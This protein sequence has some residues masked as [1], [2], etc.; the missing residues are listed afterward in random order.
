MPEPVL[1]IEPHN[2]D[3]ALFAAYSM[4]AAA[5]ADL[6]T[7]LRSYRQESLPVPI[8]YQERELESA[9]AADVLGVNEWIQW[10]HRDDGDLAT[11]A[12]DLQAALIDMIDRPWARVFAPLVE[13][14]GHEHH[15][16]IGDLVALIA[17]AAGVP[18]TRYATYRR[19]SGRTRTAVAVAVERDWPAR[20]YAA[21][22]C[23]PSQI[24]E[25]SCQPWFA[26]DDVFQEWIA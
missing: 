4:L 20:K 17:E 16:L 26:G 3:V 10:D 5:D 14:G 1:F 18:L 12:I 11:L 8:T 24:N 6:I 2:D 21:L 9:N 25:P 7:C 23:Y 22:A 13:P 15:N 19:G